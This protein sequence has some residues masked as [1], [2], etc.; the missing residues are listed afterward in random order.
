MGAISTHFTWVQTVLILDLTDLGRD[1]LLGPVDSAA[2][3]VTTR[4]VWLPIC[5]QLN[6][7]LL[8]ELDGVRDE[9]HQDVG[10]P[11]LVHVQALGQ[12]IIDELCQL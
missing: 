8:S 9:V 10:K 5:D 3:E 7:A 6:P 1:N 2:V 11:R 12:A 4:R